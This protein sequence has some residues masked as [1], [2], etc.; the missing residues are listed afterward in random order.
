MSNVPFSSVVIDFVASRHPVA[1]TANEVLADGLGS[2]ID[3]FCKDPSDLSIAELMSFMET[4][5]ESAAEVI[6]LLSSEKKDIMN[7]I[8]FAATYAV[9]KMV[10]EASAELLREQE[11]AQDTQTAEIARLLHEQEAAATVTVADLAAAAKATA[12]TTATAAA[13]KAAVAKKQ[14]AK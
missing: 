2:L 8:K 1:K 3:E 11:A 12:E 7:T 5:R 9:N 4:C 14:Q 6:S 13:V 10:E